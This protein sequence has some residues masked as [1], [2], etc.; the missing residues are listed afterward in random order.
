M[1]SRQT[2]RLDL[3]RG[4]LFCCLSGSATRSG[5]LSDEKEFSRCFGAQVVLRV[6]KENGG[7]LAYALQVHCPELY[8]CTV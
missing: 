3:F 4:F 8:L 6:V 7:A 5:N 1:C 2:K